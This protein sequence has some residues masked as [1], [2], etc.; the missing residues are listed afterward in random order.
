[1]LWSFRIKRR[2]YVRFLIEEAIREPTIYT[3][4]GASTGFDG[5]KREVYTLDDGMSASEGIADAQ[6]E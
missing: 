1:M 5:R 6:V 4:P 3:H 2:T